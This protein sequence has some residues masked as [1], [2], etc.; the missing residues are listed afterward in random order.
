MALELLT[1]SDAGLRARKRLNSSGENETGF[2]AP[3]QKTAESGKTPAEIKLD[4]FHQ[5]W[6]GSVDPVYSEF[7]Y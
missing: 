7:A 1:L 6:A 3:L 5:V 4:R 2:L